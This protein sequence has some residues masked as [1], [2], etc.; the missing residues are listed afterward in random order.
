MVVN[1]D[2]KHGLIP[3]DRE[4]SMRE[5][6]EIIRAT[7]VIGLAT[8]MSRILGLI[9][10]MVISGYFGAGMVTDAFFIAFQIPNLLRRL[11][12]E[13]TLTVSFVPIYTDYL[14][15]RPH[16]APDVVNVTTTVVSFILLILTVLGIVFTPMIIK[17]QAYGWKDAQLLQLANML[18]RVCFPY[19]LFIGLVALAMGVLNSHRHFFAPLPP[20]VWWGPE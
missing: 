19:L 7:G 4:S 1:Q 18:G 5:K 10:D 20:P 12:G 11:I 9:R 16:E 13:G 17:I 14:T 8:F 15:H 6:H 2:R 3:V